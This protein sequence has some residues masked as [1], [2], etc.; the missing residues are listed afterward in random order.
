MTSRF[1]RP[2]SPRAITVRG[3]SKKFP[4]VIA[5][6]SVDLDFPRGQITAVVGENGAGK[7]TL[8][9]ILS[10]LQRPDSG[11]V[12]IEDQLVHT[13][14]PHNLLENHGVALVPQELALCPDRTVAENV[15][16]GREGGMLPSRRR[17][18]NRARTLLDGI[19]S[20]IDPKRRAGSL[21]I[22][23]QQVVLI[24]RALA[25][26][27]RILILDEPTA[28]LTHDEVERLFRLLRRLRAEGAT[29]IYVSHRLPEVFA[30][31]DGIHVLRDGSLVSSHETA[32]VDADTLVHEMVGRELGERLDPRSH[33][34]GDVRLAVA[35][36]TGHGFADV[37]LA[38]RRN[39]IV[40][41]AGLPDSGRS[42]LVAA[43]FG[44]ARATGSVTLDGE[45][46]I[47]RHPA[48]AIDAGIAYVPAERRSQAI[49]P[50][51]TVGHNLMLLDLDKATR[52][53]VVRKR[54]LAKLTG[55]R[56]EQFD[57][58]GRA[59]GNVSQLSG[60]NQQKVILGR[61]LARSPRVLLLDEPT[62]GVDVGA[63][64]EIHERLAQVADDGAA[65]L[66]SSSDLP[67]LLRTCD[68]I[69]VMARGHISGELDGDS[70]TEER[71]MG[72]ATSVAAA[73]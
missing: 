2:E 25:R 4:G 66:V 57:V 67:E 47:L 70:A 17:L 63:K 38:V 36:L 1:P 60:G 51:M 41:L 68:R 45:P 28:A 15:V 55:E 5:L 48:D 73:A 22:A 49:F 21:G 61:W 46:L 29:I 69:I 35:G 65:V 3:L 14:T 50:A 32:T 30:L 27:C 18:V 58:R 6:A 62:R 20:T 52:F 11:T 56:L 34:P 42:E 72:L 23:E 12:T 43:L 7:S 59:N 16:L 31:A 40:G 8:M 53:G 37:S 19:G 13:F 10:G 44:A 39:E 64:A 33:E 71:V 9:T 26:E 24:V 54:T